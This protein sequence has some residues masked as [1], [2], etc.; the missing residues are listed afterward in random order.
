M[1][2]RKVQSHKEGRQPGKGRESSGK[3]IQKKGGG[4]SFLDKTSN[5]DPSSSK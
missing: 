2:R 1:D 3:K 5:E 4:G